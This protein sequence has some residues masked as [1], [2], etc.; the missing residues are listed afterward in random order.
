[1][2]LSPDCV[3][4]NR[5]TNVLPF[6]VTR[7]VLREGGGPEGYINA[8]YVDGYDRERAY[9]ATQGPLPHTAGD[10]WRMVL[11][12]RCPVIAM[13]TRTVEGGRT[14][15]EPYWPK[16]VGL[17]KTYGNVQVTLKDETHHEHWLCRSLML[18]CSRTGTSRAV[19]HLQFTEWPDFGI[20]TSSRHMLAYLAEVKRIEAD[21]D[22]DAPIVVH[23]SA[24][25][26]RTG[27]FMCIDACLQRAREEGVINVF[28]CLAQMR[29]QRMML[30]N[31]PSQYAFI[32]RTL[33]H[34]I[35]DAA[36]TTP[37]SSRKVN[38]PGSVY[39]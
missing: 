10:F 18:R 24:G 33:L 5:Y 19:E 37:Q 26:G 38:V 39:G 30:V 27:T 36:A 15:C 14:K 17:T 12:E 21:A 3:K 32:Y 31:A 35:S 22:T 4:L 2:A 13:M 11:D 28:F 9:I 6:D 29:R 16:D 7:V 20:P 8:N 25:V 23:C 34:A 1:M